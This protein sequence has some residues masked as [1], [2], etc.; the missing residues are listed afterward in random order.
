[1]SFWRFCEQLKRRPHDIRVSASGAQRFR[2][3]VG[4]AAEFAY[5]ITRRFH[6]QRRFLPVLSLVLRR[7]PIWTFNRISHAASFRFTPRIALTV[8]QPLERRSEKSLQRIEHF[9]TI[10][11]AKDHA[12]RLVSRRRR[13]EVAGPLSKGSTS[14]DVVRRTLGL[15]PRL[16]DL[17]RVLRKE[18]SNREP[19]ESRDPGRAWKSEPQRSLSDTVKPVVDASRLTDEVIQ[20]IDRR[21]LAQ[22]ERLGRF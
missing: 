18:R 1:V 16:P 15:D 21:I 17:P 4:S 5:G 3:T 8:V 2:R 12:E 10:V 19:L 13:V 9:S 6:A 11:G 7:S 14:E 20:T 22:R